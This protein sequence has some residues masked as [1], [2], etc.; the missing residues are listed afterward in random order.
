MSNLRGNSRGLGRFLV[1]RGHLVQ[2]VLRHLRQASFLLGPD[3]T[4]AVD[5]A[6]DVITI[7]LNVDTVRL[8]YYFF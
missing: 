1:Q 3:L 5:E 8:V 2:A 6:E 4:E 7:S